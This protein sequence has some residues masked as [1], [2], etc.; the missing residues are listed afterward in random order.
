MVKRRLGISLVIAAGIVP[1]PASAD[2]KAGVDAWARADYTA[3][4]REWQGP[5]DKGDADAQFNLGQAYRLGRGVKADLRKAEE[6]FG[7]AAAKGHLQAA[8]TYGLLLF[9]RGER[10][11]A[12]PYIR[13]AAD[14]GEPRAQYLLG[15]AHFNGDNVPRD[16]VRAYALASLAQQ[17]GI[18]QAKAALA[19]MDR[20]IPIE[21][22]QQGV[23]LARNLASQAEAN[24][25]RQMAA[26]D[27]GSTVPVTGSTAPVP[28][29]AST[30]ATASNAAAIAR[31][32]AADGP[33]NAG[34]DYA[35]PQNP[36]PRPVAS[37]PAPAPRTT[38]VAP[39][40]ASSPAP[41]AHS[42]AAPA[43]NGPWRVQLGAFSVAANANALWARV[44]NR[45]ELA[46][47]SRQA[48]VSG[49]VTRL[50]AAGFPS[51]EAAQSACSRLSGAGIACLVA[52]D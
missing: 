40:V 22:R 28:S 12:M 36:A 19:Q 7:K 42:A 47:R 27:L 6:L 23:A 38:G 8:D 43:A 52:R 25:A 32:A 26:V 4:V 49:G 17:N 44:K 5:A 39:V 3:A 35:R 18:E 16:W 13:A 37:T 46:G 9:Q 15:V 21:Q 20:Y 14:R 34:A 11:Q 51:R 10:A 29:R 48:V 24:R 1:Q 2:V 31:A 30:S 50:S 33:R 41:L 45:P